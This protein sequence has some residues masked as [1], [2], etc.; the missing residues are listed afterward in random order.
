[1]PVL[2]AYV[3]ELS[4]PDVQ[5]MKRRMTTLIMANQGAGIALMPISGAIATFGLSLPFFICAGMGVF[6]L[7]WAICFF[8]EASDLKGQAIADQSK[9]K[10]ES[11]GPQLEKPN[12]SAMDET[13]EK[14]KSPWRDLVVVCLFFAYVAIFI[15]VSGLGLLTPVMLEKESFGLQGVSTEETERNIAKALGL[16]MIPN[17][18]MNILVGIF[19]FIPLTK[20]VGDINV[21]VIAG[22][23]ASVNI[24]TYGF[25]PTKLWHLCIQNAIGGFCFGLVIPALGPLMASYASVHYPK[26]LAEAQAIPILGMNLSMAFGQNILAFVN[27]R[28]GIKAAWAVGG[29]CCALFVIFFVTASILARRRQPQPDR[30]SKQQQ[31]VQLEVGG[32]DVDRFV[33]S[34]CAELKQILSEN[35][36]KL[37]N[38]PVQHVVQQRLAAAVPQLRHWSD[39][40]NGLEYIEDL[41]SL[42]QDSPTELLKLRSMF[43]HIG[44][45]QGHVWDVEAGAAIPL[46]DLAR[47]I[48]STTPRSRSNSVSPRE[49][50]STV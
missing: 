6:G 18:V 30:L 12:Q 21:I 15:L 40:T 25:L 35:K 28:W 45:V 9:R 31:K 3:A 44:D 46:E 39:E 38:A 50:I 34:M 32:M 11:P 8:M 41:S 33:D 19:L 1:M 5:L 47:Q 36:G 24:V 13:Q 23:V 20:K 48:S 29:G 37:W 49:C 17:G 42:L 2:R 16:V 27:E 10:H 43:P 26:Q 22:A 4:M 14:R 7:I